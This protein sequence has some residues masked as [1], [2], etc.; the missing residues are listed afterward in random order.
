MPR[1]LE[2]SRDRP[3][4]ESGMRSAMWLCS[5]PQL[6]SLSPLRVPERA[7]RRESMSQN[8]QV[9]ERRGMRAVTL[10][11]RGRGSVIPSTPYCLGEAAL[12]SHFEH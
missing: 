2:M 1:K 10:S 8:H 12:G 4:R 5:S 6:L 11:T 3:L 7:V 9:G